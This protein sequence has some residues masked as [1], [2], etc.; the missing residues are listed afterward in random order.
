MLEVQ[1]LPPGAPDEMRV[2]HDLAAA[3][4]EADGHP[5]VGDGVWR[6]LEHPAPSSLGLVA[7]DDGRPV[8]YLHASVDGG[9][10]AR[11]TTLALVVHPAHRDAGVG[12]A[13][14]TRAVELLAGPAGQP[15]HLQLW[16]F[17][18]NDCTDRFAAGAGF[19]PERELRQMRVALPLPDPAPRWPEGI[20]VRTFEPGRDDEAWLA[21]NNR[22]FAADPDQSGWDEAMLRERMQEGWFDPAGFL[23]AF[24]ARG[25]AGFC[26]TKVHP[27]E[28]PQEPEPLGEIYVI[29]ADPDRQGSGL[30]RALVAAG[31]A[32]LHERGI[33]TGMLFVDA[34]NEPAVRLYEKLGFTT[35]RVDRAY[36]RLASA[37]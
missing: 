9:S 22:A 6:D 20:T 2:A 11:A 17:G 21:V 36:G 15:N 32:S 26:W 16:V 5:A 4:L 19:T 10:V 13:L 29:G 27:A 33:H 34:I 12:H 7:T 25:L 37:P 23:L 30:G 14:L 18:A 35:A 1:V 3:A 8:G 24:D 28:P 31:L